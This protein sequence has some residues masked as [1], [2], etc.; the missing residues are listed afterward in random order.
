LSLHP[1]PFTRPVTVRQAIGHLHVQGPNGGYRRKKLI[2][3]W[4]KCPPGKSLRKTVPNVSSFE[5]VK[6]DPDRSG[7][8]WPTGQERCKRQIGNSVPPPFMREIARRIR[9]ETLAA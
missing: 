9:E 1:Q 3:A 7:F 2:D 5:S 6:L 8:R 4:H